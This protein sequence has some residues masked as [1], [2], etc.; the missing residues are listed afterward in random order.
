MRKIIPYI[1][2]FIFG[3]AVSILPCQRYFAKRYFEDVQLDTII[4][5]NIVSY[6][7]LDLKLKTYE[8]D[9][10]KIASPS[11][12]LFP[13]E[14]IDTVY[15]DKKVY[16]A[17]E[18]EYR[19]T[20]TDEVQI[21]HSGIDSTIDSLIVFSKTSTVTQYL[22]PKEKK[23]SIGFGLEASYYSSVSVPIYFEYERMIRPWFSAYAQV[24]YDIPTR[25][26]GVGVGA[27]VF[28]EW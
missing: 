26:W 15:R 1:A 12:V 19:F 16:I 8:I 3:A 27:K 23:N 21:W 9:I 17:M 5:H 24:G 2:V 25:L 14:K 4:T 13:I 11:M 28:L 18:R 6:S 7:R 22:R 10:P 20:E